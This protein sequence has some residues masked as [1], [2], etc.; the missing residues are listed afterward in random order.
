MTNRHGDIVK[1][2]VL[3]RI[4]NVFASFCRIVSARGGRVVREGNP[5]RGTRGSGERGQALWA[6]CTLAGFKA[7]SSGMTLPEKRRMLRSTSS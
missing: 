3:V 1:C 4:A 2:M 5:A 7:L 6:I